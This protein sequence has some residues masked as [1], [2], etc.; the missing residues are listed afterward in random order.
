MAITVISAISGRLGRCECRP[1]CTVQMTTSAQ[2]FLLRFGYFCR[3]LRQKAKNIALLG[4][5][6]RPSGKEKG[7]DSGDRN[8]SSRNRQ[9]IRNGWK[10]THRHSQQYEYG[11]RSDSMENQHNQ[12]N[13]IKLVPPN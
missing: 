3:Q 4:I 11:P 6:L 10:E 9:Q 13:R 2:K 8:S 5:K 7:F 12:A 1:K